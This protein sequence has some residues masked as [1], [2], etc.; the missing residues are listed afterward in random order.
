MSF[1][2][3]VITSKSTFWEVT[4][5]CGESYAVPE[6]VLLDI[7]WN[8]VEMIERVE[9]YGARLSAR[10]YMDATEWSV[11]ETEAEAAQALIDMYYDMPLEEMSTTERFDYIELRKLTKEE[12][13]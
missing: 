3:P 4:T 11:H 2:R 6:D 9:G 12:E 13:S 7:E 1:M 10:G 5:R 8:D